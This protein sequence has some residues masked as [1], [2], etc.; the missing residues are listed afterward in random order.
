MLCFDREFAN[1]HKS[2]R[3]LFLGPPDVIYF[4]SLPLAKGRLMHHKLL[5]VFGSFAVLISVAQ[6]GHAFKTDAASASPSKLCSDLVTSLSADQKK[7]TL[8]PSDSPKQLGWHFIPKDDRKGLEL[9]AMTE[10]QRAATHALLQTLLSQSGYQKTTNIMGL[11][12]LLKELQDKSGG[13]GPI[14]DHL[15]YYV[16]LFGEPSSTGRWGVS[17]EGH[18]LSLNYVIDNDKIVASSPQFFA[19]NPAIVKT[20]NNQSIPI[21]TRLLRFEETV[22]FELVQSLSKQQSETAIIAEEAPREIRAAGE[23]QPPQEKAVGIPWRQLSSEQRKLLRRL[24]MEYIKAVPEDVAAVRWQAIKDGGFG[25]I[26]FAWAGSTV[27]GIGHYYRVQG[28]SFLIEFV[29]TQPDAAGNMA[30]HVHCVWRNMQG[31]FG[32]SIH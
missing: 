22:A 10:A 19:T 11:E 25:K 29:N 16:T 12:K 31:D 5:H 26:K 23:P 15:R 32:R 27:P 2:K 7:A 18:H 9:N 20:E 14:R 30:N 17:F 24:M 1:G 21:G 13:K 28:P 3:G 6:V 4:A 8:Y